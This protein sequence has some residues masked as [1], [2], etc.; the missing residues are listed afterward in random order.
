METILRCLLYE[1]DFTEGIET[2]KMK[3]EVYNRK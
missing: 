2:G 1:V 3:N